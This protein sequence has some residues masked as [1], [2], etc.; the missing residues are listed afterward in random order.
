MSPPR[1]GISC[2]PVTTGSWPRSARVVAWQLLARAG[3][4]ELT[5]VHRF[6]ADWEGPAS[7]RLRD[8]DDTVL[9]TYR[10]HGRLIDGG[11]PEQARSSA[12]RA[13]LADAL[14]GRRSVLMVGTNEEAARLSAEVRADLVRLGL[15]QDDGVPLD[16][17][18][19]TA[20]VGDL[21]QARRNGWELSTWDGNRRAPI[22]RET[23]RVTETREDGSWSSSA[24]TASG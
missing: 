10:K 19:T 4:H 13:W 9:H 8:G 24:A 5:E 6:A 7:L 23:Y 15:V 14:A 1:A 17:D 11:T 22:N 18:G 2:S 20:G 16:R 3:G 12:A 21:V